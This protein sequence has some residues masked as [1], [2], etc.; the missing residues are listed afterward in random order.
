MEANIRKKRKAVVDENR[1]V[2]CGACE[3][4]CPKSAIAVWKGCFAAVKEEL[5][6][7]CGICGR[8]CPAGCIEVKERAQ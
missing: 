4:V 3:A 7:G 1:C 8:T 2:A 5:C 6:V